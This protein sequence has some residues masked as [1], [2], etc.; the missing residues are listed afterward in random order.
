MTSGWDLCHIG[1]SKLICEAN[2]CTGSCVVQ[3]LPEGC[4]K[5]YMIF[6]LCESAKYTTA[7][8]FSIREGDAKVSWTGF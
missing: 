8:C 7:L 1:T 5:Q 2:R 4:S 6:H 3:F